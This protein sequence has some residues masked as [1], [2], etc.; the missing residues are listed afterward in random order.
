VRTN[1]ASGP[2]LALIAGE[3]CRPALAIHQSYLATLPGLIFR[4][5]LA[6]GLFGSHTPAHQRQALWPKDDVGVCLGRNCPDAGLGPRHQCPHGQELGLYGDAPLLGVG[7]MR[8]NR[9]R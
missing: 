7:I 9:K 3:G 5:E 1:Q 8:D 2:G 4:Y 6:Q